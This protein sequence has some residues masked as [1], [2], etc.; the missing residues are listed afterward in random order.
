MRYIRIYLCVLYV[1]SSFRR[2]AICVH[3]YIFEYEHLYAYLDLS[4]TCIF[5]SDMSYSAPQHR[6]QNSQKTRSQSSPKVA[7]YSTH[8]LRTVTKELILAGVSS[9][10]TLGCKD[11][12]HF[13]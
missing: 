4:Y 5:Y 2:R 13:H 7:C 1:Y 3:T 6:S 11:A 9:G 8:Y 10:F 12:Q